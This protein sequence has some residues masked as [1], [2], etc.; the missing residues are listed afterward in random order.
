[1]S[2]WVTLH[3]ST[4]AQG[5]QKRPSDPMELKLNVVVSHQIWVLG[6]DLHIL[7]KSNRCSRPLS[8]LSSCLHDIL[9][10]QYWQ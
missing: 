7:S 2:V 1:M 8:H 4:V 9:T 3:G 5:D 10:I 6:T